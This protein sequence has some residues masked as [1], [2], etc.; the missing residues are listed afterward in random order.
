VPVVARTL[1]SIRRHVGFT[2]QNPDDQLFTNSVFDD[3]AFGPRNYRYDEQE[4]N[5]C[6]SKALATLGIELLAERPPY[7]LSGGEKRRAVIAAV[8]ALDP[9]ILLLDEPSSDLDPHA[10]RCLIELLNGFTHTKLITS[11]DLDLVYDTCDRIIVLKDG[12]VMCDGTP[13][14]VFADS[15]K[16]AEWELEKPLRLQACPQCGRD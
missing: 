13:G 15:Q 12:D 14:E 8:L 4:V 2:F 7:H 1:P 5:R 3:V 9:D 11:H 6:V 10:R 16:L